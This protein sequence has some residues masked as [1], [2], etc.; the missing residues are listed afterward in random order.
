V[1]AAVMVAGLAVEATSWWLVSFRGRDVWRV[2]VPALG[3]MGVAAL[4]LGPAWSPEVRPAV[5][6]ALGAVSGVLLYLATRAFVVVVRAWGAFRRQS[7]AMY[8]RQGTRSLAG[9]MVLSVAVSVPGEELFWRGLFQ[10]EL[11]QAFGGRAGAAAVV[12]WAA[13]VA[14]NL[15]SWNLAIVAG[16]VVGGA[17]WSLLGWW[18]GGALAPLASHAVWTGLMLAFPVVRRAAVA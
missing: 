7:L 13:F 6:A 11:A 16:A 12:G 3:A 5:A 4:L 15:P 2:T 14:A 9:A 17:V 10:P 8:E 1:E 18:C